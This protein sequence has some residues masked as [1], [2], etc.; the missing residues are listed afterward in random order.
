L[1]SDSIFFSKKRTLRL[2]T[3]GH[4]CR[5]DPVQASLCHVVQDSG[6]VCARRPELAE[7]DGNAR[8]VLTIW[9][10]TEP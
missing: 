1:T 4:A 10:L 8:A 5:R 3:D 7:A 6:T 2:V 9:R